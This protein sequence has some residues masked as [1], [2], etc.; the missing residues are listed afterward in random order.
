MLFCGKKEVNDVKKPMIVVSKVAR[1]AAEK[2]L[3]R[4]ANCTTCVSIYQP[5]APVKLKRFKNIK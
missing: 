1:K 4:D 5:K 3:R 2:A